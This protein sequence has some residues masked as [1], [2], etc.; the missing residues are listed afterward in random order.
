MVGVID[1][2]MS[3]KVIV[4]AYKTDKDFHD[5]FI[6]TIRSALENI[7]LSDYE[8]LSKEEIAEHIADYIIGV[9]HE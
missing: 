4:E 7:S 9:E 2:A 8:N 1:L 3:C 6:A 5:A